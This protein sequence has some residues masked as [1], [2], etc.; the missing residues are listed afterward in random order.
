MKKNLNV[1]AIQYYP[2]ELFNAM[3]NINDG[4]NIIYSNVKCNLNIGKQKINSRQFDTILYN[5]ESNILIM[6]MRDGLVFKEDIIKY[7]EDKGNEYVEINF[8][9]SIFDYKEKDNVPELW[10]AQ[11]KNVLEKA[12]KDS[13]CK[14]NNICK[15][16]PLIKS[17][18]KFGYLSKY[19]EYINLTNLYFRGLIKLDDKIIMIINN[20][21]LGMFNVLEII[22]NLNID[23]KIAYDEEPSILEENFSKKLKLRK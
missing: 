11:D 22:D 6:L 16:Y 13:L 9:Y 4:L 15:Y 10:F 5:E 21:K 14:N 8:D 18:L 1:W 3:S 12:L 23:I 19:F 17:E 2:E 20:N 7:L